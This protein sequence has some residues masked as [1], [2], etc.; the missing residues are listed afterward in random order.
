MVNAPTLNFTP[1][2]HQGVW[3]IVGLLY[4]LTILFGMAHGMVHHYTITH[5]IMVSS[6]RNKMQVI[7]T[8]DP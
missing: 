8:K 2:R 3:Y 5:N 6:R 4:L 1:T 7:Q